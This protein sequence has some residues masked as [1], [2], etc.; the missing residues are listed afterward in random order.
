MK[1]EISIVLLQ[2]AEDFVYS[3]N[4]KT[5]QK[6]FFDFRKVKDGLKGEWFKKM[7]GTDDLFEFRTLHNEQYIRL[8]A[9]WD[10][11]GERETL[12]VCT[13]GLIKKTDKT[14]QKEIEKAERL[15]REYFEEKDK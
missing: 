5:R 2:D 13:H 3:L 1:F 4:E 10:K 6:V 14:P 12:I 11:T 15:K 9:F 7:K 8:F